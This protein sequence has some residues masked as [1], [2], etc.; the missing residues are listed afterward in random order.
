MDFDLRLY[1][2]LTLYL[3]VTHYVHK[4]PYFG[5]H[6]LDMMVHKLLQ[7]NCVGIVNIFT[8][9]SMNGSTC[10]ESYCMRIKEI[11]GFWLKAHHYLLESASILPSRFLGNAHHE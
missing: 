8:A 10:I 6:Q 5:R 7:I 9:V 11:V 1:V 3:H 4:Y 2:V